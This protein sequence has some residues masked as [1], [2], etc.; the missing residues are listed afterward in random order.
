MTNVT[1]KYRNYKIDSDYQWGASQLAAKPRF[2]SAGN[3]I[4]S[5]HE[6][7]RPLSYFNK[8]SCERAQ[9]VAC[10]HLPEERL[11]QLLNF[12]QKGM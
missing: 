2:F 10:Q 4:L 9:E 3:V 8:E 7:Q 11:F 5:S 6:R 1:I 12:L